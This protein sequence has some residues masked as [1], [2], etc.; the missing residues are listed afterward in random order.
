M[1][2]RLLNMYRL[3]QTGASGALVQYVGTQREFNDIDYSATANN[4]G[5][6]APLSGMK[7]DAIWCKNNSG[8]SLSASTL[9]KWEAGYYGKQTAAVAGSLARANAVVD[10][11][12][13]TVANGD[14]FWAIVKGPCKL[15]SNGAAAIT[16]GTTLLVTAAS[17]KVVASAASPADATAAL[18]NAT[19]AVGQAIEDATNVDGTKFRAYVKLG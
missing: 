18:N 17:G 8:G 15:I 10:P 9:I 5:A 13:T 6:D 4:S 1:S 16:G 3:G 14:Y 19:A 7:I 2:D 11:Y 12:I